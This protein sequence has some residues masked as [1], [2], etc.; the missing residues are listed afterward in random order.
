MVEKTCSLKL[1]V[2]A[3][4]HVAKGA[5][6]HAHVL[7]PRAPQW[8]CWAGVPLKH[9][10]DGILCPSC[11]SR[12][13]R[14]AQLYRQTACFS[15]LW[16]IYSLNYFFHYKY[17]GHLAAMME[18]NT[19]LETQDDFQVRLPSWRLLCQCPRLPWEGPG[20]S[21]QGFKTMGVSP[22]KAFPA[23]VFRPGR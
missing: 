15:L 7:T 21:R 17:Y 13:R 8:G 6:T 5:R 9:A 18:V 23:G 10:G 2:L 20:G 1:S 22:R 3:P 4:Y 14:L 19:A 11:V 16:Q 12:K